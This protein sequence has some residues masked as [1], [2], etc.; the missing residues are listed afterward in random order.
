MFIRIPDP[1]FYPFLIP[2]PDFYPFLI[3]DLESRIQ[4]QKQ[5]RGGKKF[6]VLHFIV[7]TN[8]TK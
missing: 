8:I 1:D 6:V 2:D 3:P 4:Q 7:A 5:K